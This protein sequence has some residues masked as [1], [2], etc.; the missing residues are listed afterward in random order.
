MKKWMMTA[1][2]VCAMG[3]VNMAHSSQ[4]LVPG[5]EKAVDKNEML[6][7]LLASQTET[8][9]KVT[10]VEQKIVDHSDQ[11]HLAMNSL[12]FCETDSDCPAGHMC[13]GYF[14]CE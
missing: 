5:S 13:V 1:A 4:G 10:W 12:Q 2:V 9:G 3:L 14:C 11:L 6:V 8:L 7:L